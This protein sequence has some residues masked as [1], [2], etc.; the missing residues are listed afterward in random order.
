[1]VKI[2]SFSF[3]E[4]LLAAT[5]PCMIV[6]A[7]EWVLNRNDYDNNNNIKNNNNNYY[8]DSA[9]KNEKIKIKKN[10]KANFY[11]INKNNDNHNIT[12]KY[13]DNNDN[14]DD[15]CYYKKNINDKKCMQKKSPSH[16]LGDSS[17]K[18]AHA[19]IFKIEE[20][21]WRILLLIQE[22][23]KARSTQM[24]KGRKVTMKE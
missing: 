5:R 11:H 19:L 20:L 1:M 23:D 22:L 8:N 10:S 6:N 24:I 18:H 9:T 15:K 17:D 4:G 2:F 16:S 14:Y 3:L 12:N 13:D 7:K 21:E